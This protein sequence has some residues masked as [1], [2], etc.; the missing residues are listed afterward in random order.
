MSLWTGIGRQRSHS[1]RQVDLRRAGE[2]EERALQ[3]GST[4]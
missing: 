3:N 1:N 4:S 2:K